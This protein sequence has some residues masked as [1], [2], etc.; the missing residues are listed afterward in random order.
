MSRKNRRFIAREVDLYES[1]NVKVSGTLLERELASRG[2]DARCKGITI[3][4]G[5]ISIALSKR[6]AKKIIFALKSFYYPA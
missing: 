6:D 2:Y 3:A 4:S 5:D 1:E